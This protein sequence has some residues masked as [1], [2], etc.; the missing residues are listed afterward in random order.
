MTAGVRRACSFVVAALA[1]LARDARGEVREAAERLADAWRSRGAAV[2]VE[3]PRFL[4]EDQTL[5]IVLPDLPDGACT[6]VVL[7]GPRGLGFHV[8][9]G[10]GHEVAARLP[11][12]AGVLSIER[13]SETLAPPL[14]VSSDSGRGALEIVVARSDEP[15]PSVQSV[16][17]E[18]TG[19]G[20]G[21]MP[22][23]G[24]LPALPLPEKRAEVAELRGRRDGAVIEPRF[25]WRSGVDGSGGGRLT[26]EPG[27]HTLHLFAPDPRARRPGKAHLDL[28]A[29]M[30]DEAGERLLARDRTDAPDVQLAVCLGE[31]TE[32]DVTFVGAPPNVAVLVT[33]VSWPI[34]AQL[35]FLWGPDAR[36]RMARVL[37]D[38]HV[39]PPPSWAAQLAQ[40]G[41]GMTPVP[42]EIHPGA[43]Y[44]AVVAPVQGSA[45]AI[46]L[47]VTVGG[48]SASDDRGIEDA[49]AA[50]AFC[51]GAQPRALA[52]VEAHGTPL[53][54][55]GLALFE[56]TRS[57]WDPPR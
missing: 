43:C 3:A 21:P 27:C 37:L 26:L 5:A 6:T 33:H 29:E 35:P 41:S 46:G 1:A 38:R 54:G 13:C 34:P 23:P 56:L 22:D 24:A 53:L 51:A 47:R 2:A 55:W 52:E 17:P 57:E 25:A 14:L 31:A 40:G 12:E 48:R 36:G 44:L 19:G 18:R 32:G 45:R 20:L 16:L 9:P 28:D 7:L 11:S 42:L 8:T 39:V 10:D 30:R 50:V 4:S 15:L 49:G